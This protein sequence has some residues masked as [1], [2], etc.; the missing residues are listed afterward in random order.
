MLATTL[1]RHGSDSAFHDL[2]K[3]LL[4]TFAR[5]VT[6]DRRVVRL[7]ADFVDFVDINDA[8]LRAFNVVIGR[9][10]KLQN[11]VFDVFTN[12]A[13]FGQCRC[14]G[15]SERHINDTSER[16][17]EIGLA[18]TCRTDQQNVGLRKFDI[19]ALRLM[20]ETLIVI[21]HGNRENALRILLANDIIVKNVHNFLRRRHTFA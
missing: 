15:H 13:G 19:A 11:D 18:A 21:V 5:H 16:L 2:Q 6:R 12:I 3:R 20:R 8:A 9:L 10:K 14:I 7:A 1:R 17:S 4:N